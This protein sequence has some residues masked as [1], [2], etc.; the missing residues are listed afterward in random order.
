MFVCHINHEQSLHSL[1]SYVCSIVTEG[2]PCKTSN[3]VLAVNGAGLM[4]PVL[5]VGMTDTGAGSNGFRGWDVIM[6][7]SRN[8][9]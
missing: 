2:I 5:F 1:N 4:Y 9:K 8:T 3:P 6:L 7:L